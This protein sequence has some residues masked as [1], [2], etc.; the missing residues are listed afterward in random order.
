[1]LTKATLQL[2]RQDREP[3]ADLRSTMHLA[4]FMAKSPE[5]QTEQ[6]VC[7]L[8]EQTVSI[9]IVPTEK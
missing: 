8:K 3:N 9:L 6:Q 1:M 7:V 4:I 2:H 5:W